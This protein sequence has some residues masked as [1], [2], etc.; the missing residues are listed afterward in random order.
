MS[1]SELEMEMDINKDGIVDEEE[2]MEKY[3]KDGD[4]ILNS[5]EILNAPPLSTSGVSLKFLNKLKELA[6]AIDPNMT[7]AEVCYKLI[8]PWTLVSEERKEG[9][10][11]EVL[12]YS[13]FD[14]PTTPHPEL[15][16]TYRECFGKDAIPVQE[17]GFA[18]VF[19]SHAWSNNFVD[20][21][22]STEL[23]VDSIL[24]A[25]E[26]HGKK[27]G[28]AH[29]QG[30]GHVTKVKGVVSKSRDDVLCWIDM[31][32]NNQHHF[33][34]LPFEWWSTTFRSAVKLIG[35][36]CLVLAPWIA[37]IPLTRAWCLWE[38]AC[39]IETESKLDVV[40]PPS[41][42]KD[43]SNNITVKFDHIL[44]VL[45][46]V[47][48][49]SAQS[50]N[51]GD[52]AR[53]FKVVQELKGGFRYINVLVSKLMRNWL[54]DSSR[55]LL[56]KKVDMLKSKGDSMTH[57][58][59][60]KTYFTLNTIASIFSD[61]GRHEEA[62]SIFRAGIEG[63]SALK[64]E[65][66]HGHSHGGDGDDVEGESYDL[67][68]ARIQMNLANTLCDIGTDDAR[69]EAKQL[70]HSILR[71]RESSVGFEHEDTLNAA[72]NLCS[73]YYDDGALDDAHTLLERTL[74]GRRK[75]LGP[76]HP[77]TV[78]T[79]M[80]LAAVLT[81]REE[82]EEAHVLY[83]QALKAMTEDNAN[84]HFKHVT[85]LNTKAQ[86]AVLLQAI[87]EVDEAV[88]YCQ[89]ACDGYEKVYGIQNEV[90]CTTYYNLALLLEDK[91][92][93]VL[94]QTAIE[95]AG[96]DGL[97]PAHVL[98]EAKQHIQKNSKSKKMW[99]VVRSLV[100]FGINAKIALKTDHSA[101][102]RRLA[103]SLARNGV[104]SLNTEGANDK[105]AILS[106]RSFNLGSLLD[107]DS[108]DDF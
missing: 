78:E 35:H 18:D 92:D 39:T 102:M 17:G 95:K 87:G 47:M 2:F 27:K 1:E 57:A 66:N 52:K 105:F 12:M 80:S 19:I 54:L 63:I 58:E 73:L 33:V 41:Q 75:V 89:A 4:G 34:V 82:Y 77:H 22:E 69:T 51:E 3:D 97:Y 55:M 56:I 98:Q 103:D 21:V 90:T 107:S 71:L 30:H 32:V 25:G 16:L 26:G 64:K 67:D 7:T 96:G 108:D 38:I 49:E 81:E 11:F 14:S 70:Y 24:C 104:A 6:I 85:L 59:K 93:S 28:K 5:E 86:Y 101:A 100:G 79:E 91:G 43:F 50:S 60:T 72:H 61:Q 36:T 29:G 53:I 88:S 84:G 9:V 99:A 37:P 31:F 62:A 45:G 23:F 20:L 94:A 106:N 13:N 68:Q 42:R 48:V 15:G 76:C 74:T 10:S 83:K 44:G 40:V 46:N 8:K 65:H